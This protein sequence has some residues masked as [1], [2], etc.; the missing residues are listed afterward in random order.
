[1]ALKSWL[2]S[3]GTKIVRVMGLRSNS[4]VVV[5]PSA[6]VLVDTSVAMNRKRLIGRIRSL[7]G[8]SGSLDY[9]IITHCHF[10]HCANAAALRKEF[11]CRIVQ[12]RTDSLISRTGKMAVPTGF[13][14]F[15]D[16]VLKHSGTL[17]DYEPYEADIIAGEDGT[18]AELPKNITLLTTPGHS[19]GSVSVIVNNETA[20]AGDTLFGVLHRS[21]L[22]PW[23]KDRHELV[24][25]WG[26]LLA[27]GCTLF[28]PGHG[29][30]IARERLQRAFE[31]RV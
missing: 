10:D 18:V 27:T 30:A 12:S 23:Y 3:D 8:P 22:P 9:L 6:T 28:L 4:Y 11:G 5:L 7:I 13:G 15:P 16:M 14:S 21:V 20:I 31:K 1:M 29:R 2:L 26:K 19:K 24:K 17:M 25:S